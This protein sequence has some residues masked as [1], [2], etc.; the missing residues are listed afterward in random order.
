MC[1]KVWGFESLRGHHLPNMQYSKKPQ[2]F[3]RLRLFSFQVME[4][5]PFIKMRAA[6]DDFAWRGYDACLSE[7]VAVCPRGGIGRRAWFRSMCRK[8]WGFESLRGHHYRI[9]PQ[10]SQEKRR[11]LAKVCGVFSCVDAFH[12]SQKCQSALP[13]PGSP[14]LW[15][16]RESACPKQNENSRCE[17]LRRIK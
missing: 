11:M 4:P 7:E 5:S 13:L 8:V 15:R 14:V 3:M 10:S 17:K 9:K 16:C 6:I 12:P 1:R 2:S